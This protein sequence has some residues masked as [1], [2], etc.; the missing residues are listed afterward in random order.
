MSLRSRVTGHS[1]VHHTSNCYTACALE[2]AKAE[3]KARKSDSVGALED[4]NTP[5]A[6]GKTGQPK[7]TSRNL[8]A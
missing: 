3:R 6:N 5:D 2:I 4:K 8:P 7:S 1:D